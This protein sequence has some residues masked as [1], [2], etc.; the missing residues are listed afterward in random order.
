MAC[1]RRC[2]R[3]RIVRAR[4]PA[5]RAAARRDRRRAR[6]SPG[7]TG[8]SRISASRPF[9]NRRGRHDALVPDVAAEHQLVPHRVELGVGGRRRIHLVLLVEIARHR[10]E[11]IELKD[12]VAEAVED[13]LAAIDL[14]AA[15]LVRPVAD[16]LVRAG[17]DRRVRQLRQEVGRLLAPVA[18]LVRVNGDDDEVGQLFGGANAL[19]DLASRRPDPS[20]R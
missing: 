16:E 4:P 5:R 11:Q 12:E 13:R 19:E 1:D 10:L 15:D 6:C 9:S 8:C 20:C 3:S 17:V 18:R 14:D 7:S 2:S